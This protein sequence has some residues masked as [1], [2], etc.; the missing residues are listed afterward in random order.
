[1]SNS[2]CKFPASKLTMGEKH[3]QGQISILNYLTEPLIPE[4]CE[5]G[6]TLQPKPNKA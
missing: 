3:E 1:M 6:F 2:K 5:P 4:L